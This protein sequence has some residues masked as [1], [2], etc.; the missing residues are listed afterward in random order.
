MRYLKQM[1]SRHFPEL[2]GAYHALRISHEMRRHSVRT[3]PFG[4]R[5]VGNSRMQNGDFEPDETQ[6]LQRVAKNTDVFVDVGANIGYFVCLMRALDKHVVAI[7]PSR[8][9][10]EYLVVNLSENHWNDVEVLPVGLAANTG[11]LELYGGGTGASLI[12]KWAGA[13]RVLHSKIPINT[14]DNLL[15]TRFHGRRLVIKIDVEGAEL[16]VLRGAQRTLAM[17]PTPKWLIEICLTENHP[18]G[19]NP[20]YVKVFKVLWEHGYSASSVEAG[21]RPVTLSDVERWFANRKRDFGY[22][23]FFFEK[24]V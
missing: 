6:L 20:D 10:V 19:L 8:K 7:E 23:S 17:T 12:P 3:T 2:A 22:V 9:N 24:S 11:I 1:L 4:F 18:D 13:S 21:M 14:L 15:G 5:L 16:D